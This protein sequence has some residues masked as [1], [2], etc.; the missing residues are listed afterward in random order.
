MGRD[1]R[2]DN[3]RLVQAGNRRFLHITG[4]DLVQPLQHGLGNCECNGV[5]FEFPEI[6]PCLPYPETMDYIQSK[7]PEI[8]WRAMSLIEDESFVPTPNEAV[9]DARLFPTLADAYEYKAVMDRRRMKK[10]KKKRKKAK[11]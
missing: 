11:L 10:L 8:F 3:Q 5:G 4:Y 6:D 9:D 7:A 1:G 2:R